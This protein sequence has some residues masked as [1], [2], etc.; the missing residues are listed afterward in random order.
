MVNDVV[1]AKAYLRR[2]RKYV[3]TEAFELQRRLQDV[4]EAPL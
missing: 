2:W 4:Q 1:G 3:G